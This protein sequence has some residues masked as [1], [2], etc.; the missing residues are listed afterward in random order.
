MTLALAV[1][2]NFR[3]RQNAPALLESVR[4]TSGA[5][6]KSRAREIHTFGS[7]LL[8]T[9]RSI[10]KNAATAFAWCESEP[11]ITHSACVK[12]TRLFGSGSERTR[13]T[14]VSVFD[15]C[16]PCSTLNPLSRRSVGV[17]GSALNSQLFFRLSR[18]SP[19]LNAPVSYLIGQFCFK[20]LQSKLCS[21]LLIAPLPFRNS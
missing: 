19:E 16:F 2:K 6:P 3:D 10:S 4:E 1:W 17:D 11:V 7:A 12:A 18:T 14:I 9:R 13:N 8:F 20:I 15:H 21:R 5:D